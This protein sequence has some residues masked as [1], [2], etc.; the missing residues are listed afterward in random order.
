[1]FAKSIISDAIYYNTLCN[2]I[3][4][5]INFSKIDKLNKTLF[6]SIVKKY[7]ENQNKKDKVED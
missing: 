6:N 7:I 2:A 1:M 5:K 3:F 4:M